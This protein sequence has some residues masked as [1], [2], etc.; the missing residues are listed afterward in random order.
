M[1]RLS[2]RGRVRIHPY[3]EAEL[4][5]QLA[6]FSAASGLTSSMVVQEALRKHLDRTGDLTLLFRRLD[7]LG[8]AVDRVHRDLEFLS[9]G[10]AVF[11]RLWFAHTPDIEAS[12]KDTA[13]RSAESRFGKFIEYVVERFAD[14]DR[15]FDDM[16]REV[17]AE[18]IELE[19]LAREASPPPGS[20]D[21][22]PADDDE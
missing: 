22:P 14:G 5:E 19:K 13:R 4:A 8:R 15:F 10:F 20:V 17:L 3:V 18:E 1:N 11:V 2:R 9:E 6:A 21:A 12:A 16:P 7:K